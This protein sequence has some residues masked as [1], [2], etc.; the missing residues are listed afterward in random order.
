[1]QMAFVW[2]VGCSLLLLWLMPE[3]VVWFGFFAFLAGFA[4]VIA[5]RRQIRPSA[6]RIDGKQEIASDQRDDHL[7]ETSPPEPALTPMSETLVAE[8]MQQLFDRLPIALVQID[9]R[10]RVGQSNAAAREF[11]RLEPA[12]TPLFASL[13]EGLGRS[14]STW[15]QSARDLQE[16]T[17]PEMVQVQ[18]SN[19]E[20]ILQVSLMPPPVDGQGG[21]IATLSDATELKSLEAQFVQSQKMQAIGQLAGG[22]AHDFNN[23]L[24]AISGYCDLLL[25]RHEKGDPDYNDLIQIT[26]NA[27]RA[28]A[29][30]G[31]LLAFSRKQTMQPK[32]VSV[33]ETLS[34]LTHLLSRLLGEKVRLNAE[35]GKDLP[36]AYLDGRQIEQVILNLVVNARDAMPD[37]G[38]VLI[39]SGVRVYDRPTRVDRVLVPKGKYV[40]ISV[41]DTGCGIPPEHMEK[42]FEPFFTTKETGEGTGLGLSMAYGIVKQ[43][44]G[45]IFATSTL[46]EGSE[47][48]L[49]LPA[50]EGREKVASVAKPHRPNLSKSLNGLSVMLVEDEAPVRTFV[51][52]ALAMQGVRVTEAASAEIALE[53]L[54]D[55]DLHIDLIVSD[56]VIP[57]MDGPTWVVKAQESRPDV[58]V[59]F[60]SGYAEENFTSEYGEIPNAHFLPKPFSLKQ[61]TETVRDLAA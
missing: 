5:A 57:G 29:L 58:N 7:Q 9:A 12:E 43:T 16:P 4:L 50:H 1:M 48:T 27:N 23:L 24:T 30:V 52:R 6:Q 39:K 54:Q 21:M 59:I 38:E 47:F 3:P 60:V 31:Q 18:R 11:L 41:A 15:I 56:V 26:Q 42:L 17:N 36:R 46:G 40:T 22:V 32:V 49:L 61:L 33:N 28:A 20:E 2:I 25:L 10:G 51:A 45:F 44:S 13:V 53:K 14:V 34:D 19:G 55:T 35:Y 37:G 8:K